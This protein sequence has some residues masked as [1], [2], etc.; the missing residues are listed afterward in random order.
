MGGIIIFTAIAVPFLL[1]TGPRLR[2]RSACSA[3]RSRARCS[4]FADDCTK[5]VKSRSLG[6]RGAHEAGRHDR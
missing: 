1:L 2:A 3:R 4:G 5:I 6:L